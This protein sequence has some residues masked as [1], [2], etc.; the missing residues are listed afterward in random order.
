MTPSPSPTMTPSPSPTT[1]PSPSPSATPSPSPTATP[2]QP[3]T[4]TASSSR[5]AS[6]SPSPSPSPTPAPAAVT[7]G[8]AHAI[9]GTR[10][11]VTGLWFPPYGFSVVYIDDRTV[12]CA[13]QV[14]ADADGGFTSAC[15]LPW[16]PGLATGTHKVCADSSD[17]GFPSQP[18]TRVLAC[19]PILVDPLGPPELTL[20]VPT[21]EPKNGYTALEIRVT[22]F[23]PGVVVAPYIDN[24]GFLCGIPEALPRVDAE[25]RWSRSCGLTHTPQ[26]EHV[27]C[28]ETGS[29]W[30]P[31]EPKK[32]LA[33]RTFVYG[34][35][36]ASPSPTS[37]SPSPSPA[38]AQASLVSLKRPD[39]TPESL[40]PEWLGPLG[41]A[42]MWLVWTAVRTARRHLKRGG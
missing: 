12:I 25:G 24:T 42:L 34:T 18:P 19:S 35:V 16:Q 36:Q 3:P 17:S 23:P 1:L 7:L 32:V 10:F 29:H 41:I 11:T 21:T 14:K 4:T 8:V 9:P 26:G 20:G 31:P 38:V 28:V 6:P 22:G 13:N 30:S 33:C 5:T 2:S 37:S 40:A 39:G 27:L 15:E